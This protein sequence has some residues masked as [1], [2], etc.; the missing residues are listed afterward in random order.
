[1]RIELL[2]PEVC[3]LFGELANIKYLADSVPGAQ[4]IKTSL[5]QTPAFVSGNADM[6]Y[7]GSMTEGIQKTAA[8]RLLPYK[9]YLEEYIENGKPALATG[10]ALEIFSAGIESEDGSFIKGLEL[11]SVTAKRNM[12]KRFNSLYLGMFE[13]IEVVGFKSQFSHSFGDNSDCFFAD[14][15]RGTGLNPENP[16]EGLKRNNFIATY[17]LGPLLVL[18]PLLTSWFTEK[19][20]SGGEPAFY[21]AAMS[22]YSARLAEFKNNKTRY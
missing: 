8:E 16:R 2:F 17:L 21:D 3:S 14:T 22:S 20:G 1:M 7:M 11:F 19:L 10:N 4:I 15:V 6:I 5:N 9:E 12:K 18:N 13:G